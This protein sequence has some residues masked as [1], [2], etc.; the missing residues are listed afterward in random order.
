MKESKADLEVLAKELNPVIGFWDPLDLADQDF[1][2]QGNEATIGFLRQ[3][4]IKH[5]RV[6]MAGFVGYCLHANGIHFPWPTV[7]GGVDITTTNP[8][9][10]WDALPA[11]AQFQIIWLVGFLEIWSELGGRVG[12]EPH[13]M[14]GGK[15]GKF[16]SFK[17]S[18]IKLP[19]PVPLDLFDPFGFSKNKSEEAKKRGLL[20]ELNNGRL[21]QIGLFGFFA[22]SKV[23]GSVPVLSGL[24][25]PYAGEYMDGGNWAQEYYLPLVDLSHWP[26]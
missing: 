12:N 14:R 1:W 16:N 6:A 10:I 8:P 4:E 19:H 20:V 13:Y 17:D 15:P 22:E 26:V 3:A 21:A 18:S 24:V 25:Q 23:P 2:G 9:E 7:G 5:G 11:A